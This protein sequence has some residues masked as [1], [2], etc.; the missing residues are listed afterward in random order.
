M[1]G[2][3]LHQTIGAVDIKEATMT[4]TKLSKKGST[5]K[6]GKAD[7]EDKVSIATLRKATKKVTK[8]SST[9]PS[10]SSTSTTAKRGKPSRGKTVKKKVT[11]KKKVAKSRGAG[12][13]SG[14]KAVKKT[15]KTKKEAGVTMPSLQE[16][17]EAGAHFGHKTSRWNPKMEKYIFDVRNSIHI[18]DLTQ[19]IGLLKKATDFLTEASKHGNI[20]IVGTKGQAA[21]LVKNAG[22]DHGVFYVSRR[23][24]G[25][26]LTNFK[27]INKS[28]KKL[29]RIEESL[30]SRTGYQTKK[31]MLMMQKDRERLQKIYEGIRFME[32]EPAAMLVIDTKVEKN[33]IKEARV[34]GVKVV[35]LIDTNCDPDIIDYPIP[36]NDDAIKSISLFL[37]VLV[38]SFSNSKT[39]IDLASK[40]NDYAAKLAKMENDAESEEERKR[41]EEELHQKRLKEMKEGA[42]K[43]VRVVTKEEKAVKVVKAKKASAKG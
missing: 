7:A 24:P 27:N 25:G 2:C 12:S 43:V 32:K 17:L 33:A 39:S 35:G 28:V 14:R 41:K 23:W 26:L 21:T 40:R 38:Q 5:K 29:I 16:M 8:K 10:T 15:A 19:T 3:V 34:K 13:T 18:L 36:A 31:E 1:S 37:E 22:M 4:D 42:G 9:K 20:L 11:P 6:A 30:A